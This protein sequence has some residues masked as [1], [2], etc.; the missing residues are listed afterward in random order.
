V[1]QEVVGQARCSVAR[2]PEAAA[3]H[4]LFG[5]VLMQGQAQLPGA[6][7]DAQGRVGEAAAFT[8]LPITPPKSRELGPKDGL[9]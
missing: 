6:K 9:D 7:V 4:R 3:V 1:A 8:G 2:C 5:V